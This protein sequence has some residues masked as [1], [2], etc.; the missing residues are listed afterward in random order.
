MTYVRGKSR[1]PAE[2]HEAATKLA[3]AEILVH[4]D[5]TILIAETGSNIDIKTKHEILVKEAEDI[6]KGKQVLLHLID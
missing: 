6:I 2:I 5:N 1:V 3:A 4:D